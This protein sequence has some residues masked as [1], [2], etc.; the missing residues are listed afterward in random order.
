MTKVFGQDAAISAS[1]LECEPRLSHARMAVPED[2]SIK[3]YGCNS[4]RCI[5]SQ[6]ALDEARTRFE[7]D[8]AIW[9]ADL[10]RLQADPATAGHRPS[11]KHPTLNSVGICFSASR[12][13]L[14]HLRDVHSMRQKGEVHVSQL[15][16]MSE[17]T[18]SVAP[19]DTAELGEDGKM[20][21][22]ALVGC[23]RT[24]KVSKQPRRFASSK[25][26]NLFLSWLECKWATI[27]LLD[28]DQRIRAQY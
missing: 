10:A 17:N 14:D 8:L 21:K 18:G 3:P 23:Q 16:S 27:S 2:P 11:G 7:E 20:F 15:N 26:L 9:K 12:D 19:E 5:P 6:Q 22:C 24:W 25:P 28:F 1:K 13:L 4:P